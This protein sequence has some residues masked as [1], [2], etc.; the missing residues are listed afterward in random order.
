VVGFF[1]RRKKEID[2][3]QIV[4]DLSDQIGR[5]NGLLEPLIAFVQSMPIYS[6]MLEHHQRNISDLPGVYSQL[7]LHG[8][9]QW[10]NRVY[11]PVAAIANPATADFIFTILDRDDGWDDYNKWLYISSTLVEYLSGHK[12]GPLQGAYFNESGA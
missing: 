3:R 8:T 5:R 2:P 4:E 6:D 1:R 12:E 9:G 7:R 10:S 11:I